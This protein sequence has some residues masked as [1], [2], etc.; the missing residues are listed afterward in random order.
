M[1]VHIQGFS[2]LSEIG[3]RGLLN[4]GKK[5]FGPNL[6]KFDAKKE[7]ERHSKWIKTMR[8]KQYEAVTHLLI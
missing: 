2:Y 7:L 8:Y 3:A 5:A 1:L 4:L 6:G